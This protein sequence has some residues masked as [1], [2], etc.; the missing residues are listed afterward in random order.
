MYL[1][2][3]MRKCRMDVTFRTES[4]TDG[5]SKHPC[6]SAASRHV[7][8]TIETQFDCFIPRWLSVLPRLNVANIFFGEH[9]GSPSRPRLSQNIVASPAALQRAQ[10]D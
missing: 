4:D 1:E 10:R 3:F 6:E 5:D 7:Y 2:L 8:F 9:L